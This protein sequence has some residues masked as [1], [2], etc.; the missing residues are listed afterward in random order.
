LLEE[1]IASVHGKLVGI[2]APGAANDKFP[3]LSAISTARTLRT[4]LSSITSRAA[5]IQEAKSSLL[6]RLGEIVTTLEAANHS[7]NTW[8][9]DLPL[10]EKFP[11]D[12][13]FGTGESKV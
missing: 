5:S 7:W 10:R 11:S 13:T 6:V 1:L 4:Q 8:A 2:G 12:T 9:K 3:L